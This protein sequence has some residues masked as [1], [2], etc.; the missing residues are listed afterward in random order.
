MPKLVGGDGDSRRGGRQP[1]P[2]NLTTYPIPHD[3]E[4]TAL[5][6][7]DRGI[8]L[9]APRTAP[10]PATD[11]DEPDDPQQAEL[12]TGPTHVAARRT[13][14]PARQRAHCSSRRRGASRST[15]AG[16]HSRPSGCRSPTTRAW[17]PGQSGS[18]SPKVETLANRA[19]VSERTVQ[20]HLATLAGHG[21]IQ[22]AHRTGGHAPN[23]WDVSEVS[24]SV[25]GCKDCRAGV[26]GLRPRGARV[27]A[28]VSNRSNCSYGAGYF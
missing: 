27:A 26:Q 21:L 19:L 1:M 17:A 12:P 10:D 14:R 22:T 5:Y 4:A 15:G 28:D 11:V 8:C 3:P 20:Y 16:P 6:W 23:H 2:D 24:P 7:R 25:L 13:H 9:P 18:V